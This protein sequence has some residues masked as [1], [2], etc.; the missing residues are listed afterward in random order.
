[1]LTDVNGVHRERSPEELELTMFSY[2]EC[3][4]LQRHCHQSFSHF[5]PLWLKFPLPK[6]MQLFFNLRPTLHSLSLL[7]PM[8]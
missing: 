3:N 7:I 4:Q 8:D 5:I 6:G 2:K 1:M